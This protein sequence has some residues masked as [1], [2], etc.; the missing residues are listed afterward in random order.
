MQMEGGSTGNHVGSFQE[1][2]IQVHGHKVYMAEY[3]NKPTT[4][5][6]RSVPDPSNP[7]VTTNPFSR[8]NSPTDVYAAEEISVAADIPVH[9]SRETRPKNAYVNYIIKY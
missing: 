8:N 7:S 4:N 2:A 5:N 1:D 9:T 6:I 3:Y